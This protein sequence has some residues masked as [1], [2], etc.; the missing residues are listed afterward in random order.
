MII[1]TG[2]QPSGKLH[3]G[4]YFASIAPMI[5]AQNRLNLASNSEQILGTNGANSDQM[6]MFIA[7]YHAMTSLN[8]G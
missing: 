1:L 4:N 5:A 3:I 2:L 8:D 6:L 7:N